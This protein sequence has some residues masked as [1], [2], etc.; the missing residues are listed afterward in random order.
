MQELWNFGIHRVECPEVKDEGVKLLI[1]ITCNTS[2]GSC[3]LRRNSHKTPRCHIH[4]N[5]NILIPAAEIMKYQD[6]KKHQYEALQ[7]DSPSSKDNSGA[8]LSYCRGAV[9]F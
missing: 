7:C 5:W 1:N 9:L 6:I 2:W 8:E 4:R 3:P